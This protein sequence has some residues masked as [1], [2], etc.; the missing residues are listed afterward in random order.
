VDR[1]NWLGLKDSCDDAVVAGLGDELL[2]EP[3]I[4]CTSN[5][6]VRPTYAEC[7]TIMRE[8]R[9][10]YGAAQANLWRLKD[11]VDACPSREA[12]G[13]IDLGAGWP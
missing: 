4:R 3:G 11:A 13:D 10:W 7:L 8:L 1:S 5:R 12:L 9:A 2:Q 6:F